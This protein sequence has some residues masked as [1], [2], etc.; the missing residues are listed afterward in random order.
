MIDKLRAM[1]IFA[2]V[3]EVG[4]FRGA[5]KILNLSPSVV[6]H[7]ISMLEKS[8]DVALIYRSTRKISLTSEGE[9]LLNSAQNMMSA[10]ETGLNNISKNSD[11]LSGVLKIGMPAILCNSSIT[12]ELAEFVLKHPKIN[13]DIE[14]SD[15][16]LDLISSGYDI[17]FRMGELKSS[18]LKTTRLKIE[19]RILIASPKYLDTK[20]VPQ[21]PVDL[22]AWNLIGFSPRMSELSLRRNNKT[23]KLS[24]NDTQITVDNAQAVRQFAL[25]GLGAAALPYFIVKD[26]IEANRLIHILPEWDL[27]S[28]S[29][30]AVW[31]ANLF[32]NSLAMKALEFL[33]R[34]DGIK[35]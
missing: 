25:A 5:G 14:F 19:P 35:H 13:L 28:L 11:E 27:S 22:Q 26:D 1:A 33:Q 15:N 34:A 24:W 8:L 4:S 20:S 23:R 21:K 12:D 29:I 7:H 30:N 31:P 2:K 6:S 17:A 18:S 3:A 10:A 32:K 9:V 16:R